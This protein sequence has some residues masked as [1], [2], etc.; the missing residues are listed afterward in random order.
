MWINAFSLIPLLTQPFHHPSLPVLALLFLPS[1]EVADLNDYSV[2]VFKETKVDL[3]HYL[4]A[5]S[6]I[7]LLQTKA[8][9]DFLGIDEIDFDKYFKEFTVFQQAVKEQNRQASQF[10]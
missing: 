10:T 3:V 6:G 1:L 5:I 8:L 9:A 4:S 2:V 7:L